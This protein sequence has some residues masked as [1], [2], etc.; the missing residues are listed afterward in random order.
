L[1]E[2]IVLSRREAEGIRN[3]DLVVGRFVALNPRCHES[4][5]DWRVLDDTRVKSEAYPCDIS[6]P[7]QANSFWQGAPHSGRARS[8][9]SP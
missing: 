8:Q 4:K 3:I 7:I 1:E 9:E 2:Q 5:Q 6:K